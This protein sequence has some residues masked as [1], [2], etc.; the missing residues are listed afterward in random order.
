[1][2]HTIFTKHPE[3]RVRLLKKMII[4]SNDHWVRGRG[5]CEHFGQF[6]Y[7]FYGTEP[8]NEDV[9]EYF[10]SLDGQADLFEAWNG[11]EK[12]VGGDWGF[13]AE[14]FVEI[15]KQIPEIRER[16][17]RYS[18]NPLVA[19]VLVPRFENQLH[20]DGLDRTFRTLIRVGNSIREDRITDNRYPNATYA[21][22]LGAGRT[23]IPGL[24]LGLVNMEGNIGTE[25]QLRGS[26]DFRGLTVFALNP[27]WT[28]AIQSIKAH[29]TFLTGFEVGVLERS[30]ANEFHY[31]DTIVI[32]R[33]YTRWQSGEW[34]WL[35][36]YGFRALGDFTTNQGRSIAVA[37]DIDS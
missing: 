6:L 20:E 9:D 26:S 23:Y 34:G 32:G 22:V 28:E 1:M 4:P 10:L 2:M 13:T 11:L 16:A 12:R 17:K 27:K 29:S 7:E 36:G 35:D 15:R 37:E 3:L 8:K 25:G 18:D 31:V 21:V 33:N 5:R 30:P 24:S 14:Q 19:S